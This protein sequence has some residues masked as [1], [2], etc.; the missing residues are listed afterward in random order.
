MYVE[1]KWI[2]ALAIANAITLLIL[3]CLSFWSGTNPNATVS[4]IREQQQAISQQVG[5]TSNAI[6][7]AQNSAAEADKRIANSE[8]IAESNA[9]AIDRLSK[10]ARECESLAKT[11]GAILE[12]I[13]AGN[14]QIAK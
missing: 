4:A 11:N 13:G 12:Q 10:L 8:R 1:K 3:L 5:N 14:N 2:I 7:D 6:R 9:E